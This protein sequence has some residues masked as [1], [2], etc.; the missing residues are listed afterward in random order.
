MRDLEQVQ[1]AAQAATELE[2]AWLHWRAGHGFG[3]GQL[4]PVSS[5]V[6]YS[7]E[8]PWGQPRVIFGMEAGE[9]ERL[10][11]IL[12][13][14]DCVGPVHAEV[15]WPDR[16]RQDPPR[17][18]WNVYGAGTGVPQQAADPEA[19][20][21][22]MR[23][24]RVTAGDDRAGEA[25]FAA[26]PPQRP[27]DPLDDLTSEQVIIPAAL[28]QAAAI[29]DL[30]AE[31][32]ES[33][34]AELQDLTAPPP[35]RRGS[36]APR[37][38]AARAPES[39]PAD[40]PAPPE[41][42]PSA[43]SAATADSLNRAESAESSGRA[44]SAGRAKSA[45]SPSSDE[46]AE[47]PAPAAVS[48]K[49]P[50]RAAESAES[51]APAAESAKSP[52][53]A[54]KSAESSDRAESAESADRA[55]SAESLSLDESSSPAESSVSP[56]PKA[57]SAS[58]ADPVNRQSGQSAPWWQG[59]P[60]EQTAA[61]VAEADAEAADEA[62]MARLVPVSRLNRS[63]KSGPGAPGPRPWPAGGKAAAGAD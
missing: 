46:S 41:A 54:A 50:A 44:E 53:R 60:F 28:H 9:A 17:S 22:G 23:H 26:A 18:P 32:P 13:G 20:W 43:G 57:G 12:N 38:R 51:P 36:V 47:S 33:T 19:S 40:L 59:T 61:R 45:E 31:L 6:G 34:A 48:T 15:T 21:P 24:D 42:V 14:H 27:S 52:A 35:G 49:S 62:A 25:Q 63:R 3:T 58:A 7:A 4:P 5:Y 8:E 39:L 11:A 29:A 10:A 2:R 30:P 1:R 16:Y 55:G 56:A 37:T